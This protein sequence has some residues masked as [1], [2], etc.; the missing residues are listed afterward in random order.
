M[1]AAGGRVGS[2]PIAD[3]DSV[4]ELDTA[5]L[6]ASGG[7]TRHQRVE[8]SGLNRYGCSFDPTPDVVEFGSCTGSS[9]GRRGYAAARALRDRLR[10]CAAPDRRALIEDL[11]EHHR[12]RIIEL[13]IPGGRAD[14]VITPSGTDAELIPLV[15]FAAGH[16]QEIES[17]ILGPGEVGSGTVGAAG[18]STFDAH[19]PNGWTTTVGADVDPALAARTT[20]T[21]VRIRDRDGAIRSAAAVDGEVE[22]VVESARRSGRRVLLHVVAHSKTGVHAPTL[23]T[24]ERLEQRHGADIAV[25]V[26]A[27]QGRISRRGL[28]ASLGRGHMV[29]LTGSKFFGGPPFSGVVLI[30]PTMRPGARGLGVF[31]AGFGRYFSRP[32]LPSEW[33]PQRASL[34]DTPNPG[35]LLRW[36][37]ALAEMDAYYAVEPAARLHVLRAFEQIAPSVLGSSPRLRVDPV[38]PPVIS[39]EA[40]RVLESKSTVF[41]FALATSGGKGLTREELVDVHAQLYREVDGGHVQLSAAERAVLR[42]KIHIGQPVAVGEGPVPAAVLR[43]AIGGCQI[44]DTATDAALGDTL[45]ERVAVLESD[46]VATRDKLSCLVD[47]LER[48]VAIGTAPR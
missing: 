45:E 11:H 22:E 37:A 9:V 4:L 38:D 18:A 5:S 2:A 31:P 43:V 20:V 44:V 27:A 19:T 48:D 35:L 41:S 6:L 39:D 33:G 7:D 34:P 25:V 16:D 8:L 10:R 24:V 17:V 23:A 14:A 28:A 47:L 30:P 1:A 36:E 21:E 13:M 42:R 46:L 15:L 12:R 26:D 40:E 3:L 29:I 32:F